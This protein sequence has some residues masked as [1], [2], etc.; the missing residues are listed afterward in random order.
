MIKKEKLQPGKCL[1]KLEQGDK[2]LAG[3]KLDTKSWSYKAY[4]IL[5]TRNRRSCLTI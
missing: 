5:G 3:Q 4:T 2:V 1:D